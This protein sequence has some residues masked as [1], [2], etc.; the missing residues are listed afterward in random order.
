MDREIVSLKNLY[1][2]FNNTVSLEDINLSIKQNTF[3]GIIGPN[4]GGKT[5]LLRVI[6]G[7]IKPDRG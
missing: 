6:L 2:Y 1:V 5:T 4:G 3:L 7:L